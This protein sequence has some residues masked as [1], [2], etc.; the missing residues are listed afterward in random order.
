[1]KIFGFI[2]FFLKLT[3][4]FDLNKKDFLLKNKS[5][6]NFECSSLTLN[7]NSS[8]LFK[9]SKIH[10]CIFMKY[11]VFECKKQTILWGQLLPT[12]RANGS[13]LHAAGHDCPGPPGK[14]PEE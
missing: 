5:E 12:S 14:W 11:D 6:S 9:H 1:M 7:T 4:N 10:I 8:T 2:H 3:P 13:R